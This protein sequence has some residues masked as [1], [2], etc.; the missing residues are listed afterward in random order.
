MKERLCLSYIH[1]CCAK[2]P[3][4]LL[5]PLPLRRPAGYG[6]PLP[7]PFCSVKPNCFS[8]RTFVVITLGVPIFLVF[9]VL[10][11]IFTRNS[12][13]PPP[14]SVNSRFEQVTTA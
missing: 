5:P 14:V 6:K 1:I 7:V 8:Y 2:I 9:R 4:G 3:V 10:V 12:G 13:T 11:I